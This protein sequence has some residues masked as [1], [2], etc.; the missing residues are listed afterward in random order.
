MTQV[1]AMTNHCRDIT[2]TKLQGETNFLR[3]S[4]TGGKRKIASRAVIDENVD[5]AK[6]ATLTRD[7]ATCV[8]ASRLARLGHDLEYDYDTVIKNIKSAVYE[9]LKADS[10][11][12][13]NLTCHVTK[14]TK[15]WFEIAELGAEAA[16]CSNGSCNALAEPVCAV[17]AKEGFCKRCYGANSLALHKAYRTIRSCHWCRKTVHSMCG[18][19]ADHC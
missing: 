12:P 5:V 17:C 14:H 10:E 15:R 16:H 4:R 3:R 9:T 2:E 1:S 7:P 19:S 6:V 11:L 13:R 18:V 8:S